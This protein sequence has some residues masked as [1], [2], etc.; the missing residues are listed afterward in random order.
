[1]KQSDRL[2]LVALSRWRPAWKDSILP[3][4]PQTVIGWQRKG[5]RLF[6]RFL[7]CRKTPGR[8]KVDQKIRGLIHQMV[9]ANPLWGAPRVMGEMLKL[10]FEVSE[11]K[12]PHLMPRKPCKLPSQ[13][14]RAFLANP[15]K[16]LVLN[17]FLVLPTAT[18]RLLYMLVDL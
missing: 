1:M 7:S 8:P 9:Q 2:F 15:T 14:W 3:V 16:E 11:R 4:Q 18:F 12:V 13:T 17:V 10:G 5:F 6:R